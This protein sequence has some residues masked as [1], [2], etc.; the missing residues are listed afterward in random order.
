MAILGAFTAL[1]A[2][3]RRFGCLAYF[4]QGA[5]SYALGRSGLRQRLIWAFVAAGVLPTVLTLALIIGFLS[6]GFQGWINRSLDQVLGSQ[7]DLTF[8][9]EADLRTRMGEDMALIAQSVS[10]LRLA[11]DPQNALTSYLNQA[12]ASGGFGS[13]ISMMPQAA[14]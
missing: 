8:T 12:A 7:Q 10:G 4:G 14:L 2:D 9:Y 11:N 5:G 13:S 3:L 1:L 6:F